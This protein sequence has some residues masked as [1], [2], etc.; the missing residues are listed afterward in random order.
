MKFRNTCH[1]NMF[2]FSN[3]PHSS[4]DTLEVSSVTAIETAST[5][6]VTQLVVTSLQEARLPWYLPQLVTSKKKIGI[7][8]SLLKL[9]LKAPLTWFV[10]IWPN[11]RVHREKK[12]PLNRVIVEKF[13]GTWLIVHMTYTIK[14]ERIPRSQQKSK[15]L[16]E[17]TTLCEKSSK[18]WHIFKDP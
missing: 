12:K 17:S 10:P 13:W 2:C 1:L 8:W 5:N 3:C 6:K 9:P 14:L 7:S 15:I 11:S 18:I 16:F 4:S